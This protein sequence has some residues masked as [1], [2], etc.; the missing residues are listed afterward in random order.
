MARCS[1]ALLRSSDFVSNIANV[2]PSTLNHPSLLALRA[3]NSIINT[4]KRSAEGLAYTPPAILDPAGDPNVANPILETLKRY[5]LMVEVYCNIFAKTTLMRKELLGINKARFEMETENSLAFAAHNLDLHSSAEKLSHQ[6]QELDAELIR[7]RSRI[8]SLLRLEER[9]VD[10]RFMLKDFTDRVNNDISQIDRI[11][12]TLVCDSCVAAAV[13]ARC[14]WLPEQLRQ[15][16]M[17]VFRQAL[18]AR[19]LRVTMGAYVL[20]SLTDR[21]QI[22]W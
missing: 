5:C 2:I 4:S 10:L 17:D 16:C 19:G 21:L 12:Q 14:G 18:T 11:L 15:E 1:V 13:F 9:K 8:E 7:N 22:R 20:G 3:M 6:L